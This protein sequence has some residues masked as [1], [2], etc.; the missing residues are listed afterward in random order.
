MKEYQTRVRGVT[1]SEGGAEISVPLTVGRRQ[2]IAL[3]KVQ[4]EGNE[5][6]DY[7]VDLAPNTSQSTKDFV[8]QNLF[9]GS[10]MSEGFQMFVLE[11]IK[12]RVLDRAAILRNPPKPHPGVFAVQD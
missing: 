12:S 2:A 9:D 3:I 1:F 10:A 7:S 11:T 4:L 5:A 6:V 8:K